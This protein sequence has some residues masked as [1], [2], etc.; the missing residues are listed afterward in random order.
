M[1]NC[2][3]DVELLFQSNKS[4]FYSKNSL[5]YYSIFSFQK[6]NISYPIFF[7][8]VNIIFQLIIQSFPFQNQSNFFQSL[9]FFST[10]IEHL[11]PLLEAMLGLISAGN[12]TVQLHD[13]KTPLS[14]YPFQ[15][16]SNIAR[17]VDTI[18]VPEIF[19]ILEQT[20]AEANDEKCHLILDYVLKILK[21]ELMNYFI[22][23]RYY[24]MYLFVEQ[25]YSKS[26]DI[27]VC[28]VLKRIKIVDF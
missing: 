28:N 20:F 8:K 1:N 13:P 18:R 2:F 21:M 4:V 24:P 14:F 25:M 26:I 16:N 17:S 27:Q 7:K 6:I 15:L 9:L 22:L 23:E 19:S 3:K 12:Q 5:F 10:P 11:K